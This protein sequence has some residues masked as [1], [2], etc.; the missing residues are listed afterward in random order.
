MD[1]GVAVIDSAVATQHPH[2]VRLHFEKDQYSFHLRQNCDSSAC[3]PAQ[4]S[5][6]G[7]AALAMYQSAVASAQQAQAM[8]MQ[9]LQFQQ[10]MQQQTIAATSSMMRDRMNSMDRQQQ[11]LWGPLCTPDRRRRG[12]CY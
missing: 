10:R 6:T 1:I 2:S 7:N 11:L 4:G 3:Y 12:E 9:Q 5:V 8:I